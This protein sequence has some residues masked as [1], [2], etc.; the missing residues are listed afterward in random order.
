MEL[1]FKG[2]HRT[3]FFMNIDY[4]NCFI[5]MPNTSDQMVCMKVFN[6]RGR[7]YAVSVKS[8][9]TYNFADNEEVIPIKTELKV[10]FYD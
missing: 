7:D 5:V 6:E 1:D 10:K 3:E 9:I 4:G 8:G 2:I